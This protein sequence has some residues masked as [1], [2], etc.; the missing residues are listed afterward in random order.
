MLVLARDEVLALLSEVIVVPVTQTIRSLGSEVVLTLEDGMPVACAL[1]FD[2][3][4]L[5]A[6]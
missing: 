5:A 3:V 1:N 4:A 2:H 6:R